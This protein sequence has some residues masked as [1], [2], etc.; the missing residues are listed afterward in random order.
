MSFDPR[1]SASNTTTLFAPIADTIYGEADK[2]TGPAKPGLF[3]LDPASGETLWHAPAPDICPPEDKPACNRGFSAAATALEDVVFS[4]AYD[5]HM[6][7]YDAATGDLLWD[8]NTRQ[9]FETVSG[10]IAHGGSI[11]ADGPVVVNGHV[12]LNSGY[13]FGDRMPGNVLLAFSVPEP[14]AAGPP[15]AQ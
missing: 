3:A 4:G 12:L 13:T 8:F 5:G 10:E 7:A 9:D 6:R 11:E 1:S 15:E 14:I 2:V